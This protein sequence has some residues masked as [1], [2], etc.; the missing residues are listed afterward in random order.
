MSCLCNA[1]SRCREDIERIEK[2]LSVISK[3]QS[4]NNRLDANFSTVADS[5]QSA[6]TP[7][8]INSL[9]ERLEKG[10]RQ[11]KYNVDIL[12]RECSDQIYSLRIR[13]NRMIEEDKAYHEMRF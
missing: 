1:I 8:N 11:V 7:R 10:N 4:A 13:L 3:M 12:E 9:S 2:M 6:V 5:I